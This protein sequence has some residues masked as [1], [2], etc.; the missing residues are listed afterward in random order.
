MALMDD[1]T[2]VALSQFK[3]KWLSKHSGLSQQ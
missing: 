1:L 3:L 2:D